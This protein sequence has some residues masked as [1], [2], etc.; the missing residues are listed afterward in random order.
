MSIVTIMES[1]PNRVR[2]L[3]R[4]AACLGGATRE[5]LRSHMMPTLAEGDSGQFTNLLRET[6]RLGLL[7]EN[8]EGEFNLA[9]GIAAREV[10]KDDWFVAFVDAALIRST[11]EN[12]ENKSFTYVLAWLLGQLS[13]TAIHWKSDQHLNMQRQMKGTETYELTNDDRF[14][15]VCYW[16]RFLGFV[17]QLDLGGQRVAVPDPTDAIARY[18][19]DVFA[20]D[21]HLS[22]SS[23]LSRLSNLCPVLEGGQVRNEIEARLHTQRPPAEISAATSLAL[24]R[25]EKRQRIRLEM[26]SDANAWQMTTSTAAAGIVA[27]RRVSDVEFKG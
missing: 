27:A 9:A 26:N 24:W 2:S 8:T 12:S 17:T 14:A 21:R 16:A 15:M 7:T 1:T 25:L 23:F 5:S 22:L 19:P 4:L 11:V 20:Q 6:V 3:V 10:D 18:L 13:G